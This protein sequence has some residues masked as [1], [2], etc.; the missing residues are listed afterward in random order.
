GKGIAS[1]GSKSQIVRQRAP[2]VLIFPLILAFSG[3]PEALPAGE[4]A[5]QRAASTRRAGDR[6]V[7]G[8]FTVLG[9]WGLSRSAPDSVRPSQPI[10]IRR[11]SPCPTSWRA[12]PPQG[13]C[14]FHANQGGLEHRYCRAGLWRN[15]PSSPGGSHQARISRHS[16]REALRAG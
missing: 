10:A 13:R 9:L 12:R 2:I 1:G 6:E 7:I 4:R 15:A 5:R 16:I 3:S 11:F 8:R 14:L